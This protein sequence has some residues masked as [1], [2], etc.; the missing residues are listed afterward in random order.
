MHDSLTGLPN[1]V[2]PAEGARSR[3]RA[4]ATWARCCSRHRSLQVHQ[5]QLRPSRRRPADRRRRQRAAQG[6]GARRRRRRSSGSAA[7]NSRSICR[8]R[9][10]ARRR[11]WPSARSTRCATTASRS[12]EQGLS[13]HADRLDR[14]R[15]LSVPRQRRA[16]LLS[17][18]DI[19]MYQAKEHG[20][21]RY[22]LLRPGIRTTCAAR[23]SAC[24]GRSDCATC[25]TTTAWCSTRSPS[26]GCA[27][28]KPVH[29]E[30]LVRMR[31]D[32]GKHRPAGTVHRAR[33]VAR[34][35]AGNRHAGGREAADVH[36]ASSSH[37]RQE[38]ALLR[39]PVARQSSP[40]STGSSASQAMLADAPVDHEPARVRDHGNRGDVGDRRHAEL[41]HA[42]EGHGLPL[43]ARRFRRGLQL[44]L[45]PE[46]LRRRLPEDRRQLHPR[47]RDR[48]RQPAVRAGAERRRAAG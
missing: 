26:C 44:V 30:I 9:C 16:A 24:T 46:A 32:N 14:H 7:T 5:R 27:D 47:P 39:E 2:P 45:L 42:D 1:R 10:A 28:Q 17:N 18:V 20:R 11:R 12:S 37:A 40:T 8:M 35:G 3:A 36:A 6:P 33:R 31:D 38:A 19:A 22:V 13:V 41:H 23:T 34:A 21:N 43:R 29:H 4:T 15:A 48:R 25:S